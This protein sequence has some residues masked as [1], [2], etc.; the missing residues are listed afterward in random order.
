MP[1][2]LFTPLD[3][4]GLTIPNRVVVSPMCQYQATDGVP[5]DWHL[6][7][8]G[9]F[10]QGG[11]GLIIAEAT[12]VE[13]AGR[14][15][16]GCP[17]LHDDATE[18][19]WARIVRFCRSVG[20]SRVGIQLAHAGR[21][22][23]TAPPW[24]GAGPVAPEDGGWEAS[25]PSTLPFQP[26]WPAPQA[27]DGAGLA[28]VRDAFAEAAARAARAGFD[29]VEVHAAH[30]YLLHEFLSPLSNQ[31]GDRY[32][33]SLAN[34]MRF[35]LDVFEAVRAAFPADRPVILRLSATDWVE[36]GWDLDGTVAFARELRALGC[37][38]IDV[39]S[40][41][42]DPG[43]RIAV[44]PGYQAGFASHVRREAGIA[45]VAV[46][47]ITDPLQAETILRSGQ[48]DAVAIARAMLWDPRWAWHA[49]VA[50]GDD[51]T[52]PAPYA[53]AHP[54][55]AGRPFVVRR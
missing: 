9:Q 12:G 47:Q 41:G 21:K 55:Q 26:H 43:Q 38:M 42:L 36:G 50:L 23:S 35:P 5:G 1:S 8:L 46:G 44:G 30:G 27:L 39:S 17:S 2:L 3:L 40:G 15:S 52:L 24:E 54:S 6:V 13:P 28:R 45:T 32:G 29:L 34:R 18:A 31:R 22:A 4:R 37:D 51:V 19:A 11:P 48:A 20:D 25:A 14:I 33:G 16:P 10:A 49:A 7:H 53:R